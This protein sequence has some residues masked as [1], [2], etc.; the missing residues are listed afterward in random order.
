MPP[1]PVKK[2][3]DPRIC[4]N[5]GGGGLRVRVKLAVYTHFLCQPIN[6]DV[7]Q[8][9]ASYQWSATKTMAGNDTASV[10]VNL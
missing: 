6:G 7:S 3:L 2:N 4:V 10:T 9:S 1:P 5:S 8:E